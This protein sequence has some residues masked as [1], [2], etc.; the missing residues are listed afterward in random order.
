MREG[1]EEKKESVPGEQL[2]EPDSIEGLLVESIK[3]L[4][5]KNEKTENAT[6]RVL[7]AVILISLIGLGV[8]LYAD[9]RSTFGEYSLTSNETGAAVSI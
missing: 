2:D 8:R 7:I 5:V 9:V 4:P 3:S 6:T 1:F